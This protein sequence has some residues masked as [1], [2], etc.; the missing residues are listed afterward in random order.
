MTVSEYRRRAAY[1][2]GM[3]RRTNDPETAA[4]FRRVAREWEGLAS[5]ADAHTRLL[6][7]LADDR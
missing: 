4:A 7:D 3:G 6:R 5:M 2:S 1:A